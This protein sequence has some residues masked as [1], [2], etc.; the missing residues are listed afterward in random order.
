MLVDGAYT[1]ATALQ[2]GARL[3]VARLDVQLLLL[4][5]LGR[6][7]AGR[8]WLLAHDDEVLT[9]A[10]RDDFV[11][12]LQQRLDDVPLAYIT[13][14]KEFFGLTLSVT[15]AVLDPRA[16]TEVLVQW[17]LDAM[18]TLERPRVLD[19]GTGSGAVALALKSQRP[20]AQVWAC[21]RSEA[22][23]A[24]ARSNGQRLGLQ[25]Q[26]LL[27]DWFAPLRSQGLVD[28]DVVV[29]N[30]PY[31]AEGDVHLPALRHEPVQ[32]LVAGCDGLADI[33][34]IAAD[35][36]A[37]LRP[38]G[39]LLLEHGW[40]QAAAVAAIVADA[41]FTEVAHRRDLAGHV[42]CTGGRWAA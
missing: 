29:A 3:G 34:R 38:G 5:V 37:F 11:R 32:A 33:R 7:A 23:L 4:H 10:Q 35:A 14:Q 15:P 20:D 6:W 9:L 25:V 28:L 42:R 39:W 2:E 40:D 19:L 22:A 31:I 12:A 36:G 16:D 21:D 13:G 18:A 1:V 27:G 8:A 41:G 26:W 24:Q 30:P 17:A